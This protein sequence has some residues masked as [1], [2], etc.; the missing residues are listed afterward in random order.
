MRGTAR[1]RRGLRPRG[2][3]RVVRPLSIAS[4]GDARLERLVNMVVGW[5]R[6]ALAAG[7]GRLR[8]PMRERHARG[9]AVHGWPRCVLVLS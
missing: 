8:I 6:Q 7:G 3:G 2:H 5:R 9:L 4:A 1:G